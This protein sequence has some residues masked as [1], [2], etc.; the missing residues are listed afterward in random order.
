MIVRVHSNVEFLSSDDRNSF[1]NYLTL[2][3]LDFFPILRPG[4]GWRLIAPPY[5]QLIFLKL[6][7][8][9][10]FDIIYRIRL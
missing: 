4:L 8:Y 10:K 2:S 7:R 9:V 6:R 5:V 1:G 3:S